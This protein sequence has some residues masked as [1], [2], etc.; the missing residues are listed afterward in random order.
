MI[1]DPEQAIDQSNIRDYIML[2]ATQDVDASAAKIMRDLGEIEG[3]GDLLARFGKRSLKRSLQYW[4][5]RATEIEIKA[6]IKISNTANVKTSPLYRRVFNDAIYNAEAILEDLDLVAAL[7]HAKDRS[8]EE[9]YLA[10]I[11]LDP[12]NR[13]EEI[14]QAIE[15]VALSYATR[16]EEVRNDGTAVLTGGLGLVYEANIQQDQDALADVIKLLRLLE[17]KDEL[18]FGSEYDMIRL[19]GF[20]KGDGPRDFEIMEGK[21]G[22]NLRF[23]RGGQRTNSKSEKFQSPHMYKIEVSNRHNTN[24]SKSTPI[25]HNRIF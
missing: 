9:A 19:E 17:V 11:S 15:A 16:Q 23:I 22:L 8:A 2:L 18:V 4:N 24:S 1:N 10:T 21:L 3:R 12:L 7:Q 14:A 13:R 6:S 25:T 5:R 20:L